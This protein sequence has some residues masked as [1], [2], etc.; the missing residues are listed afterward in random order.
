MDSDFVDEL[1]YACV[2][3]IFLQISTKNLAIDGR[4]TGTVAC[5]SAKCWPVFKIILQPYPMVNL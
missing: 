3:C 2:L 1:I 4:G 5:N